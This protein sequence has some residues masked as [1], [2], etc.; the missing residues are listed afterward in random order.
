MDKAIVFLQALGVPKNGPLKERKKAVKLSY[1]TFV[2]EGG[3]NNTVGLYKDYRAGCRA[4][5]GFD[6]PAQ[7]PMKK[8]I[9]IEIQMELPLGVKQAEPELF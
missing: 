8:V 2:E 1:L 4:V 7:R 3:L 6:L 9:G 5:L